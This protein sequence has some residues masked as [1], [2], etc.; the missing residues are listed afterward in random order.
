MVIVAAVRLNDDIRSEIFTG[1]NT[2]AAAR[3]DRRRRR[4]VT[5]VGTNAAVLPIRGT[6]G[7]HGAPISLAASDA[8]DHFVTRSLAV[9]QKRGSEQAG[10]SER[11]SERTRQAKQARHV[12]S[13]RAIRPAHRG[14]RK[15]LSHIRACVRACVIDR[16]RRW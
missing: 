9:R 1:F 6:P 2:V 10:V 14:G 3:A 5:S 13:D 8:V 15:N 7:F 12:A 16:P 4:E 11:K